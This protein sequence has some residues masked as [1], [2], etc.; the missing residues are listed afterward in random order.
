VTA[1]LVLA[2]RLVV[3]QEPE[4]VSPGGRR[5]YAR[6]D[7]AGIVARAES[8]AAR[9]P[10]DA[11]TLL[12]LGL[13]HAARWQYRAAVAAYTRAIAAAPERAE[14][15]RHR[16]HRYISLRMAD[17]A[18]A[19]LERAASLD[20]NRFDIWYHL[21]LAYYLSGRYDA[22]VRAYARCRAVAVTADDTVAAS[23][24]LW[25]SLHRANRGA[26]AGVVVAQL[27]ESAAVRENVAYYERL[28]L[29]AG[30]RRALDL[31]AR[32]EAGD[33][34]F[35]TIGYG[36]ANWLL[37]EGDTLG[38]HSLMREITS[39]PYWPAFGFIAAEEDLRRLE[40]HR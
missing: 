22:A 38:A 17:R 40:D 39:G 12:A 24:W 36:L 14:L 16:G 30:R 31:R 15:Y 9:H 19:D 8:A 26:A 28:L 20:T 32:M 34:E 37:V 21:G 11:D 18:V 29:Y 27:P 25:M 1:A 13:A 10:D 7:S 33:L 6:P 5:Y 4:A 23:D 3:N 2:L 35:A